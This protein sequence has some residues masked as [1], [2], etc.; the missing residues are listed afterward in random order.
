MQKA[1][2]KLICSFEITCLRVCFDEQHNSQKFPPA[3][4]LAQHRLQKCV[5]PMPISKQALR[6]GTLSD[7]QLVLKSSCRVHRPPA[8]LPHTGCTRDPQLLSPTQAAPETPSS[9]PPHRLHQRPPDPLP[10]HRACGHPVQ[11]L[12]VSS[13]VWLG[14][15][16]RDLSSRPSLRPANQ[17][18]SLV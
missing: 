9:S 3:Q 7:G 13:H 12:R 11:R 1:E 6:R 18:M 8:P 15:P 5:I 10:H 14:V 17:I 4:A 2:H 16:D